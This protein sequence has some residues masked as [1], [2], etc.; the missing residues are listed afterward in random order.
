MCRVDLNE[1]QNR[2]RASHAGASQR[3]PWHGCAAKYKSCRD[4]TKDHACKKN[5]FDSTEARWRHISSHLSPLQVRPKVQALAQVVWRT[6]RQFL[7]QALPTARHLHQHMTFADV[8]CICMQRPTC[9][10]ATSPTL[11]PGRQY[12]RD[13]S[14][15]RNLFP[16]RMHR[17]PGACL[18][19]ARRAAEACGHCICSAPKLCRQPK[20]HMQ[21]WKGRCAGASGPPGRN[22][23]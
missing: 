19:P 8:M 10:K 12:D 17:L 13:L 6:R 3:G 21:L 11:E 14:V 4:Q 23:A 7:Q 15:Q 2:T 9:C 16:H 18:M 5:R 22:D 20:L 1:E